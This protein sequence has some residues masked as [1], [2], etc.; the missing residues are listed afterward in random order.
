MLFLISILCFKKAVKQQIRV[1]SIHTNW[2][3]EDNE[4][5]PKR[6]YGPCLN[7][8]EDNGHMNLSPCLKS[9]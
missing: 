8:N 6:V 1:D 7:L 3:N 2:T 4:S 9:K 5:K